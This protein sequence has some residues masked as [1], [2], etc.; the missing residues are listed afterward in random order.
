MAANRKI[1]AI[2][3]NPSAKAVIKRFADSLGM[4]E[5]AVASRVYEWFSE[6]DDFVRKGVLK[7]LPE[8]HEAE[9]VRLALE[10]IAVDASKGKAKAGR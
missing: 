9:V 2:S 6:Q 7:L 8:G 10:R 3:V 4:K 1:I 5:I